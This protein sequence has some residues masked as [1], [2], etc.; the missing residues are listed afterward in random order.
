VRIVKLPIINGKPDYDAYGGQSAF[1]PNKLVDS[2]AVGPYYG[3]DVTLVDYT[4]EWP[5]VDHAAGI[6]TKTDFLS[7]FTDAELQASLTE[8]K[9]NVAVELFWKR[10]DAAGEIDL[11][12]PNVIA[13]MDAM[14]AL[15]ILTPVRAEEA[16]KG[17][18]PSGG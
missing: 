2:F 15:T 4:G 8:A 3:Q 17:K 1:G 6:I 18:K 11:E 10:F 5:I 13:A 12:S 16:K 9:T 7:L 14:A